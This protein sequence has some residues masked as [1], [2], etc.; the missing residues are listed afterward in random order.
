[1]GVPTEPSEN[2]D[3]S[4]GLQPVG[5]GKSA[6]SNSGGCEAANAVA[7]D[8]GAGEA[9][10]GKDGVLD[11]NA[12]VDFKVERPQLDALTD[13]RE[14]EAS[15]K[16]KEQS[17][18]SRD[19]TTLSTT[20]T[21]KEGEGQATMTPNSGED[22]MDVTRDDT[23]LS[24]ADTTKD[25]EG[26]AT[27]TP[28][29]GEDS[30]DVTRNDTTLSTA[31]TMKEG[32]GQA[33]MTPNS[34]EDTM[35]EG[36]GQSTM[37][38]N[39]GEGEEE[40]DEEEDISEMTL[41]ERRDMWEAV[42]EGDIELL[43]DLLEKPNAEI[44]MIYF[45]ENL[46]MTALRAGQLEMAEFLLDNGVDHN[47]CA[48]LLDPGSLQG[49]SK[50]RKSMEFYE[51][52]CRQ[53]AYDKNYMDI[54][55]IIDV[56]NGR[57]FPGVKPRERVPRFRR[58]PTTVSTSGS[59]GGSS[60]DESDVTRE[61]GGGG[62][63][64]VRMGDEAS[65]SG[66][67]EDGQS[68][69]KRRRKKKKKKQAGEGGEEVRGLEE[70]NSP[71]ERKR[72]RQ[73]DSGKPPSIDT[74]ADQLDSVSS[75]GRQSGRGGGSSS[76]A[77][78][79]LTDRSRGTVKSSTG[80]T[81]DR[82]TVVNDE[83]YETMSPSPNHYLAQQ[84]QMPLQPRFQPPSI[85]VKPTKAFL[86][87]RRTQDAHRHHCIPAKYNEARPLHWTKVKAPGSYQA[88]SPLWHQPAAPSS[89]SSFSLSMKLPP[90]TPAGTPTTTSMLSPRSRIEPRSEGRTSIVSTIEICTGEVT[91][92]KILKPSQR[93]SASSKP[94]GLLPSSS[95]GTKSTP[96]SASKSSATSSPAD[97]AYPLKLKVP[98]YMHMT[99]SCFVKRRLE[100]N[101]TST[102]TSLDFVE[103]SPRP[104][105]N[106]R[107]AGDSA[108]RGCGSAKLESASRISRVGEDRVPGSLVARK[109]TNSLLS[110]GSVSSFP[111][112]T[113]VGSPNLA[114]FTRKKAQWVGG[115][116]YDDV[117]Y[118][119]RNSAPNIRN[120][121]SVFQT[122]K[123]T[124]TVPSNMRYP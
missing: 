51:Y 106:A 124:P 67:A 61:E 46:V 54:V 49:H 100:P 82:D 93:L 85:P 70:P 1:M 108:S 101:F 56:F 43:E 76:G 79:E 117:M 24:T 8:G 37:T 53:M 7:P 92:P 97:R 30:M 113:D 119:H 12:N 25:G 65:S 103:P 87:L 34:G 19:D 84:Q 74:E 14:E 22:S 59:D 121:S 18:I 44:R 32:E 94:A 41:E 122:P 75:P 39:S 13:D 66:F 21:M 107:T 78:E 88:E 28:N 102:Y 81:E 5:E 91:K 64:G 90:P 2:S 3:A 112:V 95:D 83:G 31:D 20:D 9:T 48:T 15:N 47:Y 52:S 57:L 10:L 36:E 27:M 55:E 73:R 96:S 45:E 68:V 42:R 38:P 115:S 86:A 116:G 17:A 4:A 98:S 89:S 71:S 62:E 105:A 29:S 23:T 123:V 77:W 11:E 80:T 40:E 104:N 118:Q 99:T 63:R 69:K 60:G 110:N 114:A 111:S 35:K 72:S 120:K 50:S 16:D 26:Q 109:S 6:S 33:T 58:P